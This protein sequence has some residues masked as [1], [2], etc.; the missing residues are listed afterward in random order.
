MYIV[1][2]KFNSIENEII[3]ILSNKLPFPAYELVLKSS[4]LFNIINAR[5]VL[6]I[7]EREFFILRIRKYAFKIAHLY[8]KKK[9]ITKL[10]E[11]N[12]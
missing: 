5:G 3:N 11:S 2:N 12:I 6:S 4:H 8:L 10:F 7:T 1:I 9:K